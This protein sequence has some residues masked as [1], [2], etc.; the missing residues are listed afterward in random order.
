M[1]DE[2]S[3]RHTL[4]SHTTTSTD[5]LTSR[6][7]LD[8]DRIREGSVPHRGEGQHLDGVGLWGDQILD[9]GDHAVLDIMNL[10]LV[11]GPRRLHGVV[12]TVTFHLQ[13]GERGLDLILMF[14]P[15][16][17]GHFDRNKSYGWDSKTKE[18]PSLTVLSL[19][20][21]LT[22][23]AHVQTCNHRLWLLLFHILYKKR[24]HYSLHQ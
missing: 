13:Y 17:W 16:D 1:P 18:K 21:Q 3:C 22:D 14:N 5:S 10:P 19:W 7:D 2:C 20:I 8:V 9:G 23:I 6:H 24:S 11:H 4:C 12:D 15:S